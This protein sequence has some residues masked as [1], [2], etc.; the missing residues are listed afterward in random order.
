VIERHGGRLQRLDNPTSTLEELFLEIVQDAEARP[1][2]RA[3]ES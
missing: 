3:A 1:G 2:R